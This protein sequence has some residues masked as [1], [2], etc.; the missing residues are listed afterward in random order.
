MRSFNE[1]NIY[2]L[3]RKS[4]K[5]VLFLCDNNEYKSKIKKNLEI[6]L[7]QIVK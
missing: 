5:N 1:E 6:F 4:K 3:I 7:L 2:N